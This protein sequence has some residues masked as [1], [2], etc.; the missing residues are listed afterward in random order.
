MED[1]AT[2]VIVV[3]AASPQHGQSE[4]RQHLA[5]PTGRVHTWCLRRHGPLLL[6]GGRSREQ[7]DLRLELR[8]ELLEGRFG[9]LELGRQSLLHGLVVGLCL[10][11]RVCELDNLGVAPR[12]RHGGVLLEHRQILR[13]AVLLV[14]DVAGRAETLSV[15]TDRVEVP[16]ALVLLALEVVGAREGLD[17]GVCST[18]QERSVC[19][20]R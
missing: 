10:L 1:E 15:L 12:R 4:V 11:Q 8:S 19:Q 18:Q 16:A 20:R 7:L 14:V 6:R 3:L 2:G 5:R 9:G 17:G 13:R